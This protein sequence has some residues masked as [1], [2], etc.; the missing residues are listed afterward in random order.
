MKQEIYDITILGAGSA[1]LVVASAASGMGARVLLIEN[2]KMG[3]DCLNY[4]CVPSKTFLRSA[5]LAGE[6]KRANLY[7]I[8]DISY[9]VDIK[10][11]M[12][13]VK[14]VVDKIAVH[15]SIERFTGLGVNVIIGTP[16]IISKN[17]I[18]VDNEVFETK[19]IVIATGSTAALPPIEGLN[20]VNYYTNETIFDIDYLPKRFI[21]LGGGPIGLEL[22]QGFQMLGSDVTVI[23]R[24]KNLFGKDEKEVSSIMEKVFIDDGMKLELDSKIVKV[25]KNSN[26]EIEVIIDQN[27]VE[28]II[29]GDALL[30]SLGRVPNTANLGLENIGVKL[31]DRNFIEVDSHL[32]TNIKDVYACGDVKG[33]YMFTHSAGYEAGVVVRNALVANMFK[34]N[35]ENIVWTTYTVPQVAHVGAYAENHK[36]YIMDLSRNDRAQA[37]NDVLGFIKVVLDDDGYVIGATIVGNKADEILSTYALMVTKKIKLSEILNVIYPYPTIGELTKTIATLQFKENA[38]EW[39][40]NLLKNIVRR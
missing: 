28:K 26:N 4:G 27:N 12:N 14:S 2:R 15:D 23:D 11:V 7:G 17:R 34:V 10:A 32:R 35:Y 18:E 13:R 9:N 30:V 33:G 3:G 1:G 5:H 20:D 25:Q 22:G 16:K 40:K 24:G 21:V 29:I 38:K 36:S 37:D 39:Q 6:L 19:K 8:N 31:N